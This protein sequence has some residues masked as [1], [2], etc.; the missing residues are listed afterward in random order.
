VASRANT[1]Q[2]ERHEPTEAGQAALEA[3]MRRSYLDRHLKRCERPRASGLGSSTQTG[4]DFVEGALPELDY[5]IFHQLLHPRAGP[6]RVSNAALAL[7]AA[8]SSLG[9]V[10][11]PMCSAGTDRAGRRKDSPEA[12]T[13]PR[14]GG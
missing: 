11:A 7:R 4:R 1:R 2:E 10:A 6:G 8:A 12:G 14:D 9:P 5:A 3:E 13:S